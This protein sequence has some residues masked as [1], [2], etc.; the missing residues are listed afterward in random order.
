M[1]CTQRWEITRH[2]LPII[3]ESKGFKDGTSALTSKWKTGGY[4]QTNK[5]QVAPEALL[6]Q[7]LRFVGW[8]ADIP[9]RSGIKSPF[10]STIMA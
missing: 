9:N 6:I 2:C 10:M 1:D 3:K 7:L 4:G 5:V 8:A